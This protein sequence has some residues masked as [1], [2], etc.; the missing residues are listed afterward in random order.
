[1]TQTHLLLAAAILAHPGRKRRNLAALL[2]ALIPDLSIYALFA[3][4]T[5]AGI[6]QATLWSET[7]W[8]EPWQTLS[9]IS[10]SAPLYA[11]FMVFAFF[12][13]T[14]D[15][16][17]SRWQSLP[18]IFSLAALIH[19]LTDFTVHNEDAHIHFWPLSEWRFY[20]PLSYWDRDHYGTFVSLFEWALGLTLATVLFS[21]FKNKN[22]RM[23]L[24]I[25]ITLYIA[26]PLFFL[27]SE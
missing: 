27:L 8:S 11:T 21:R 2:G 9:K 12:L 4:A 17:R 18:V 26:G 5:F 19:L 3:L 16:G 22:L 1:M 23:T 13:A 6:P 20:S 24:L 10:N 25:S 15:D 7:Y 14:P